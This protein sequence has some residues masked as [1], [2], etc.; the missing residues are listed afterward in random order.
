MT[1]AGFNFIHKRR[2]LPTHYDA[3]P[4]LLKSYST[5]KY[6][7]Q[8]REILRHFPYYISHLYDQSLDIVAAM[9]LLVLINL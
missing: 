9:Y 3:T 4:K 5:L 8:S 6:R 1:G 7:M 2:Y